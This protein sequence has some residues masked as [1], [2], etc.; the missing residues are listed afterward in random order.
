[1]AISGG[2]FRTPGR[3]VALATID[4][5]NAAVVAL[6][7]EGLYVSSPN[8]SVSRIVAWPT[9]DSGKALTASNTGGCYRGSIQTPGTA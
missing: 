8:A 9:F 6:P 3:D 1:M 4:T 5:A 2:L 7:A